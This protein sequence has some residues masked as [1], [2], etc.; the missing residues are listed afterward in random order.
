MKG[1]KFPH[2]PCND[3]NFFLISLSIYTA[4]IDCGAKS[5]NN[6]IVSHLKLI[7]TV[8]HCITLLPLPL[9]LSL[10]HA[11]THTDQYCGRIGSGVDSRGSC[12]RHS[13]YT[14]CQDGTSTTER[15]QP[16]R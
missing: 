3:D 13:G 5:H 14:D 1:I 2:K 12:D 4:Y 16:A 10:S 11:H 9:S 8:A 7:H 6:S 15:L